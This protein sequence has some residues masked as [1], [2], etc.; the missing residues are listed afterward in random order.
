MS[1]SHSVFSIVGVAACAYQPPVAER[2]GSLADDVATTDMASDV[3]TD[4][5]AECPGDY[6]TFPAGRYRHVTTVATWEDAR[7]D[8]A[9]DGASTHLVVFANVAELDA[10]ALLFG[11]KIWIG[12]SDRVT[13]GTYQWVTLEATGGF[14]P[15]TG[16]PWK[17]GQPNDGGGGTED[18]VEMDAAGLWDDRPCDNDTNQYV[19]ECDAFPDVPAQSDPQS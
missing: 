17:G 10:V 16:P 11:Q 5:A 9:N 2:D 12:L 18:C 7:D 19:C 6:A 15:A 4:T 13:T 8:C 1:I 3:A 14:P